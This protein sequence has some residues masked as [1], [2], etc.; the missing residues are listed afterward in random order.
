MT[1]SSGSKAALLNCPVFPVLPG[2]VCGLFV[3]APAT[4]E[5][6]ALPEAAA[7]LQQGQPE[8]ESRFSFLQRS[9]MTFDL[10][11]PPL[12]LPGL[13][14]ADLHRVQD[15]GPAGDVP[16]RL[17]CHAVGHQQ[18]SAGGPAILSSL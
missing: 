8:G 6:Q 13:P 1:R 14:P 12:H 2:G 3:G 15:P 4:D 9:L 18:V 17:D 10:R 16:Q 7:G 11:A 5:R